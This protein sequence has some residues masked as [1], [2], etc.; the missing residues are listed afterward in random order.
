MDPNAVWQR[1]RWRER[2]QP[3]SLKQKPLASNA[4]EG[5]EEGLMD[6]GNVVANTSV[7]AKY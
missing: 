2:R 5:R 4:Q 3:S 1:E 6:I 7:D